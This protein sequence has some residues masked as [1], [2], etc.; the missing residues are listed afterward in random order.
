[1]HLPI[2]QIV[3]GLLREEPKEMVDV[4][5]ALTLTVPD[6]ASSSPWKRVTV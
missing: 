1:M 3:E 2:D 5:P 4:W 6:P